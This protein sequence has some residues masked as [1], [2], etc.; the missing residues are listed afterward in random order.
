MADSSTLLLSANLMPLKLPTM[1][2]EHEKLAREAATRDELPQ[3]CGWRSR[4]LLELYR[5]GTGLHHPLAVRDRTIPR[6]GSTRSDPTSRQF[7]T[8]GC[9]DFPAGSRPACARPV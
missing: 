1:L 3:G 7:L 5:P 4:D 2:A 6:E 9:D 8:P